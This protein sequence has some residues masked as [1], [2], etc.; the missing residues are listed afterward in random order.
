MGAHAN[1]VLYPPA[2]TKS[3][4]SAATMQVA[5]IIAFPAESRSDIVRA[6]QCLGSED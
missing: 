2:E 6:R 3:S 1:L 5:V 4:A